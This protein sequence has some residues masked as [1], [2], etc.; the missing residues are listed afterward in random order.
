MAKIQIITDAGADLSREDMKDYGIDVIPIKIIS[1]NNEYLSGVDMFSDEIYK[2]LEEC[3]EIPHTSQ[4]STAEIYDVLIKHIKAGKQILA[5]TLSSKA[6]GL[7]NN[8]HIAKNM[9]LEEYPDAIIEILDT[10]RFS[11]TYGLPVILASEMAKDGKEIPEIVA[12]ITRFMDE[13][14]VVFVPKTLAYLEKGGRIN[15]ASL[16]FGNLLDIVPI[17]SLRNGLVE[18]IGKLRGRKK[19]AKKLFAY[20]TE[21][22]PDQ[23]GNEFLIISGRMDEEVAEITELL[24]EK[25]EN[26]TFRYAKVGPTIATHIGPVF[27]VYYKK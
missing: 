8:M 12:E 23:S 2:L 10:Q 5:I 6:S 22:I 3:D 17:L 19:L 1:G 21:T 24:K 4:P 27:A 18:A 9:I 11:Y 15:K 20:L 13:H 14:D 25:Y 26:V 16:V 7:H